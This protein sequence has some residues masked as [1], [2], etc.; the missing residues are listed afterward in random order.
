MF[1]G[2]SYANLMFFVN[3]S[4]DTAG[5]GC[6]RSLTTRGTSSLAF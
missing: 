2:A 1:Y 5:N 3:F 6:I 4:A